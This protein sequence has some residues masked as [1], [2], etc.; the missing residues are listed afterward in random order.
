VAEWDPLAAGVTAEAIAG[1]EATLFSETVTN[2]SDLMLLALPRLPVLAET[3]WSS[4]SGWEN[5]RG[6]L[7]THSPIWRAR[8]W[9]YFVSTEI[10]WA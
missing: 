4:P 2:F 3:A 8:N 1:V 9:S 6:R 7:A 10:D 5:L